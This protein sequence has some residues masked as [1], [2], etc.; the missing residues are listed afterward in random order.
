MKKKLN[1][2]CFLNQSQ[3]IDKAIYY[4][5]KN[6]LYGFLVITDDKN[7]LVGTISDGDIRRALLKKIKT[8]KKVSLIMSRNPFFLNQY[9]DEKI[10]KIF[11]NLKLKHIPILDKNGKVSDI[12]KLQDYYP[13]TKKNYLWL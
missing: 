1:K 9:N 10:K 2:F 12:I 4:L 5:N 6:N 13:E 3:S 8:S 11:F 7:N